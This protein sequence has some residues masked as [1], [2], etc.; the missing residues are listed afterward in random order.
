[1]LKIDKIIEFFIKQTHH[2]KKD[3]NEK[4]IKTISKRDN[5]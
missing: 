1:M 3:W 5:F 4:K 2:K